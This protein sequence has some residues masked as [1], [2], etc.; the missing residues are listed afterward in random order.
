MKDMGGGAPVRRT[1][2]RARLTVLEGL[3]WPTSKK[4]AVIKVRIMKSILAGAW[5]QLL[6]C[7]YVVV[8]QLRLLCPG[9]CCWCVSV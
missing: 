8:D 7:A 9:G 1:S 6:G 2:S 4:A 3:A 5:G